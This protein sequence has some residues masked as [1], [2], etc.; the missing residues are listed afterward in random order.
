MPLPFLADAPSAASRTLLEGYLHDQHDCRELLTALRRRA[1][2]A[3]HLPLIVDVLLARHLEQRPLECLYFGSTG[4]IA[5]GRV[6][7]ALRASHPRSLIGQIHFAAKDDR[8]EEEMASALHSIESANDFS[9]LLEAIELVP[10]HRALSF[11]LGR[12]MLALQPDSVLARISMLLT[13]RLLSEPMDGPETAAEAR[14]IY[15]ELV[16]IQP[17][18]IDGRIHLI[19]VLQPARDRD[20]ILA[21]GKELL[22]LDPT[23]SEALSS[24][25][26]TLCITD[27]APAARRFLSDH[28]TVLE[29][30]G[31]DKTEREAI[32]QPAYRAVTLHADSD[33]AHTRGW[34]SLWP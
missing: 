17:D 6:A 31:F 24:S 7:A 23:H 29:S 14:G 13:M 2:D 15:Q 1:V 33:L 30:A 18:T 21:L 25:A 16:G 5:E 32:L 9:D 34:P 4:T 12:R 3:G 20:E 28:E 8:T 10:S 26:I 27:G 22:T 19:A 11:A